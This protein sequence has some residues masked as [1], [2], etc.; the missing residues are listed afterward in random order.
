MLI[1]Y[2][3]FDSCVDSR[4]HVGRLATQQ[5]AAVGFRT[6]STVSVGVSTDELKLF[7]RDV[8]CPS[9]DEGITFPTEQL[10]NRDFPSRRERRVFLN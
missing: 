1:D 7:G 10:T 6:P 5:A 9:S 8:F 2:I 3:C 4:T